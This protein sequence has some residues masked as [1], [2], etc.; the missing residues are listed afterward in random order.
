M[1]EKEKTLVWRS[2]ERT[3]KERRTGRQT[4]VIDGEFKFMKIVHG[5]EAKFGREFHWLEVLG[6]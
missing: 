4:M 2:E 3:L 1:K 5:I 6:N